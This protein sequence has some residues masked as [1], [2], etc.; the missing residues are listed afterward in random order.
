MNTPSL[1]NQKLKVLVIRFSSIGDIVLC[2][3]VLRCL[4]KMEGKNT[5]VHFLTR[6]SFW[7]FMQHNPYVDKLIT[8]EKK[9]REVLPELRSENYDFVIDLHNNLRSR[10]VT[11]QLR[12]PCRRF[13][14]LNIQKW[15]LT[16]FHQTKMPDL[17]IVDR[18]MDA[19]RPLGVANDQQGLDFFIPEEESVSWD[20]LPERFRKGFT[21]FVIGGTY[22]TKRLPSSKIIETCRQI[23]HPVVLL[24]G[25]EDAET[26]GMIAQSAG[27]HVWNACGKFSLLKSADLVK[28]S[29][30]IIAHDTGLM[31]IAAAFH[32]PVASVW[33]N[34]VPEFGMYPYFPAGTNNGS[35][36]FE[37]K[38]LSCRPCSKIGYDRCP[39]K[40][41]NCM[42]KINENQLAQWANSMFNNFHQNQLQKNH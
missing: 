38:N 1:N 29:T 27:N 7:S 36:I 10:I 22:S 14:K 24:G 39:K 33:G 9:T 25:R 37:V 3:P 41:F 6:N 12:K 17:H 11:L 4:K 2:S 35:R 42:N 30:C 20:V 31:H 13:Y 5:E 40:H 26:G 19:A 21:G 34:T 8:I 23:N 18:Y 15:L 28:K 16:N 32:K